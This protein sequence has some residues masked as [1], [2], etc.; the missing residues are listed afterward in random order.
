MTK[1]FVIATD[2]LST[3]EEK[4][5][6]EFIKRYGWWHWLPNFWLAQDSSDVLTVTKIRDEIHKI[7]A[8]ARAWV[9]EVEPVTWSALTKEDS[10]GRDGTDWMQRHFFKRD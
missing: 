9:F 2:P 8:A 6:I 4:A 1:R 7:N 10:Q 5:F 3:D